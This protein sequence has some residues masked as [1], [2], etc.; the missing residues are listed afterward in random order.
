[1]IGE[2]QSVG[3]CLFDV[4]QCLVRQVYTRH[5]PVVR[6]SELLIVF[7]ALPLLTMILNCVE[8]L[9]TLNQRPKETEYAFEFL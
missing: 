7:V 4:V 6:Q 8:E 5:Q 1:M 9:N 2:S 3:H